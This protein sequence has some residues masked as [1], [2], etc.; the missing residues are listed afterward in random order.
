MFLCHSEQI[1]ES[2]VP[3]TSVVFRFFVQ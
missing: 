3:W 1:E 2:V